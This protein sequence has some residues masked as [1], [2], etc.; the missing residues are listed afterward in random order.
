M[1]FAT[2][3]MA[4]GYTDE[5][6]KI[7]NSRLDAVMTLPEGSTTRD[8]E[9]ADIRVGYDGT[10]YET[11]GEAVRVQV[12]KAIKSSPK[13]TVEYTGNHLVFD[14]N[15]SNASVKVAADGV[16]TVRVWHSGR[17]LLPAFSGKTAGGLTITVEDD[18][19]ID[20]DG[21]FS[22]GT[23]TTGSVVAISVPMLDLPIK[24]DGERLAYFL[25][26]QYENQFPNQSGTVLCRVRNNANGNF[27]TSSLNYTDTADGKGVLTNP[28]IS[29]AVTESM[30]DFQ[31]YFYNIP[32]GTVFSHNRCRVMLERGVSP[33]TEFTPPS[34]EMTSVSVRN[35]LASADL[36]AR[37]G[38]NYLVTDGDSMTV[39]I[40]AP[41]TPNQSWLGKRW[42]CFGD[43][44]TYKAAGSTAKRYF[45]YVAAD[46]GL[47]TLNY[48]RA[49]TGYSNS[50]NVADGEYYKRMESISPE[51]FD[52]MTIMGSTNDVGPMARGE[53]ELGTYTD[54]GTATVCGC[55]NTTIDKFYEL[56]PFKRL[57]IMTMLP[58]YAYG[59]N[60]LDTAV[61]ENYVNELI[62]I[63]KNRGIPCLDLYHG[64]G[65]RP[66]DQANREKFFSD[67]DGI[68][69]NDEGAAFIAPLIR[70]F[71]KTLV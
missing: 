16:E 40:A 6:L 50:G 14:S 8:A 22:V 58:T 4:K 70:E 21:T 52:F 11:A 49:T 48:G 34:L 3:A 26:L 30:G 31:I 38:Y 67:G 47:S 54:T 5:S 36:M 68:H 56:A 28:H 1:D 33:S 12:E 69:P 66:W 19:T 9:V 62:K 25:S 13:S 42:A 2:L 15:G 55:I 24:L 32:N 10:V 65:L 17:N 20:F 44:I 29:S 7:T 35:G 43:S 61:V 53:I 37:S 64:S 27:V 23:G 59:P 63:C 39:E 45:D 60:L 18:G 41:D 46:L 51:T 57:G 71:V